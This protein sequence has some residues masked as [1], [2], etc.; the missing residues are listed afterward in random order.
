MFIVNKTKLQP[1][2]W[3]LHRML[4]DKSLMNQIRN[5]AVNLGFTLPPPMALRRA[6]IVCAVIPIILVYPFIQPYF[7]SGMTL[8]AV[9]E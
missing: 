1:F 3:I 9:K 5:G 7:T 2:A 6:T 8:G 4:T